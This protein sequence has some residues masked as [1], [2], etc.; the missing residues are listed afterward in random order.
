MKN[1]ESDCFETGINA[2]LISYLAS[3]KQAQGYHVCET[4]GLGRN[5]S[6]YKR[7]ISIVREFL[8]KLRAVQQGDLHAKYRW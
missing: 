8:Q 5:D 7:K 3:N 6:F 2:R 4:G 1:K